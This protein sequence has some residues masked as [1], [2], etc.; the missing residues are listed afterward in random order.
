M[1]GKKS[2]I[3][4]PLGIAIPPGRKNKDAMFSQTIAIKA[5]NAAKT[6]NE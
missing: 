5:T 4:V 6:L 2:M 3:Y 1:I